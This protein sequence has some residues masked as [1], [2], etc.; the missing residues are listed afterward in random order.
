MSA[1]FAAELVAGL[2][3]RS[4][5]PKWFYDAEGSR[6]FEQ[7]CALPEY[8]VWRAEREILADHAA[9]IVASVPA[10]S[11]LVELGG[12]NATKTSLLIRAALARSRTLRY[13]TIDISPG[14]ITAS[15]RGLLAAEPRLEMLGICAEYSEGLR[16]LV[17]LG[18]GSKLVLWLGSSAGNFDRTH[19]AEILASVREQMTRDDRLLVGLDLRKDADTLHQ[20]YDDPAG[21]TARFNHNLLERLNRELG[22]HF[23]TTTF[24][25][26]AR[27]LPVEGRVTM[28]LESRIDQRVAIEALGL[29]ISFR[30]GEFVHTEDSYKYSF[31][32]IQGLAQSAGFD[33]T[34]RWLDRKRQFALN[35]FAPS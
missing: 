25:Y 18:T 35:L 27:Y 34:R 8:Y 15:A 11:D 7:I 1:S 13:V 19:A 33:A 5:S 24:R 17:Q 30:A 31:P 3:V 21:V 10:G 2:R 9:E 16:K 14:A 4:I 29:I 22:A 28:G 26:V 32:E 6:L 12:G 23:D 20:A